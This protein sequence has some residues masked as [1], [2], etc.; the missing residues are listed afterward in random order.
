[1]AR[2]L[3]VSFDLAHYSSHSSCFCRLVKPEKRGQGIGS[4]IVSEL[5]QRAA[6]S[7]RFVFLEVEQIDTDDSDDN[8]DSE[9]IR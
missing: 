5:V 1:M 8:D 2:S 9:S 7:G 4:K 3:S 6:D